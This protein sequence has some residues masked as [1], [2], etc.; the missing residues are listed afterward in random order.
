MKYKYVMQSSFWRAGRMSCRRII[1]NNCS[2]KESTN[3]LDLVSDNASVS[4]EMKFSCKGPLIT[5]YIYSI[6]AES[7]LMI[8]GH[9]SVIELFP[10]EIKIPGNILIASHIRYNGVNYWWSVGVNKMSFFISNKAF[11]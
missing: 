4:L 3:C 8:P 6:T 9:A 2:W 1:F 7:H 10:Q 5:S 11:T